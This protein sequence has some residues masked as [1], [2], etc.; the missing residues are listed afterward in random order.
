MPE[1][2]ESSKKLV[3]ELDF[4]F[5]VD[6]NLKKS[7]L[8]GDFYFMEVNLRTSA[9]LSLDTSTFLNLPLVAFENLTKGETVSLG[10][11]SPEI[12][13]YWLWERSFDKYLGAGGD[14]RVIL[15]GLRNR[16]VVRATESLNDPEPYVRENISVPT[17]RILEG[18]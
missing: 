4:D 13:V 7:S 18:I 8:T 15:D 11:S 6:I 9:N 5:P 3:R 16:K 2:I 12:G 17:R 14:F 1:L 10:K